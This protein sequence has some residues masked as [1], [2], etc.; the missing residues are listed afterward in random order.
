M[1]F[2]RCSCHCQRARCWNLLEE[3]QGLVVIIR[4]VL[5][6]H[7]HCQDFRIPSTVKLSLSGETSFQPVG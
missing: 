2:K 3:Y 6:V 1:C 5:R 7:Y 4:Y